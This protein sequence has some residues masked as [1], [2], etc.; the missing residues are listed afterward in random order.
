MRKIFRMKYEPCSGTCYYTHEV[1]NLTQLANDKGALKHLLMR[2]VAAHEPLCGNENI[3]Y[4]VD[5]D[6]SSK[7][8]IASFLQYGKLELFAN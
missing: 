2:M 1:V 3:A 4:G 5:Y 8:F 7:I 6:E